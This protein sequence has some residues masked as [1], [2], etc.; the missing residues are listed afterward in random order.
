MISNKPAYP[1]Y[2]HQ[3]VSQVDGYDGV[4]QRFQ[5]SLTQPPAFHHLPSRIDPFVGR[6]AE[7]DAMTALLKSAP[8][9]E[10]TPVVIAIVGQAGV[11][12]SELAIQFAHAIQS[13]YSDVQIYVNFRSAE[14]HPLTV[15]EVLIS[16][17]RFWSVKAQDI[18]TDLE[19]CQQMFQSRLSNKCL[20]LV[21]DNVESEEQVRPLL[22]GN[23]RGTVVITSRKS[24]AHLATTQF[25]VAEL[26]ELDALELLER[27]AGEPMQNEP[28][29]AG[30]L[31]SFCGR[32]PLAISL[33]GS[34]LKTQSSQHWTDWVTKLAKERT[35]TAQLQ[36]SYP[37]V[38]SCFKLTYDCLPPQSAR[39]LRL[40]G[41]MTDA[42]ITPVTASVLL[43][44]QLEQTEEAIARLVERK[45]LKSV[46]QER[47][48]VTHDLL[49]LLARGQ[50]AVEESVEARQAAR[51][52]FNQGYLKLAGEMALGL[53]PSTR[54][55]LALIFCIQERESLA[56]VEQSFLQGAISWFETER[57]NL[58]SA[59]EWSQQT[60]AW[61]MIILL[62]ER[63]VNFFDLCA[64]WT[65]WQRTHKLAL[66][67]AEQL[68]DRQSMACVLNNLGNGYLRQGQWEAAKERYEQS[69]GLFQDIADSLRA[70]QTLT[71]LGI[72]Y[73]QQGDRETAGSLWKTALA[74][75]SVGSVEHQTLLKW[76]QSIDPV[77]L[78]TVTGVSNLVQSRE[79]ERQPPQGIFQAI[80]G[81]LKW[82]IYE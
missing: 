41:L 43:E 6:Q 76:M 13:T 71:N 34:L 27:L 81:V 53:T 63:L 51:L 3:S 31:V 65:T 77:L 49:R 39:L 37:D 45:L 44:A 55:Q 72:L 29:I 1:L 61:K 5:S 16:I 46:G 21:L 36:L 74:E 9:L 2:F 10:Q 62:T 42:I 18:P 82:L 25:D 50:L 69:L 4:I 58:L 66:E 47:Y 57:F 35:R 80:G 12:K 78:Q 24:L 7:L 23:G 19:Q 14:T 73:Y 30:H 54:R 68:G 52:R 67:A 17:L 11:G 70:S 15:T 59:I 56:I 48:R 32:S 38:R 26:P 22:P 20:L 79:T 60:E 8:S 28:D 33:I 64:D 40:I 75:L